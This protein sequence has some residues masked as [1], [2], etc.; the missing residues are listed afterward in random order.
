MELD[1]LSLGTC[2]IFQVFQTLPCVSLCFNTRNYS[3]VQICLLFENFCFQYT[4]LVCFYGS[5]FSILFWFVFMGFFSL[6]YKKNTCSPYMVIEFFIVIMQSNFLDQQLSILSSILIIRRNLNFIILIWN[7]KFN[8]FFLLSW[9]KHE[10]FLISGS[11]SQLLELDGFFSV[12]LSLV[13][14]LMD[15]LIHLYILHM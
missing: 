13:T 15:G 2:K 11:S 6:F 1:M 3:F 9:S 12:Q 5:V 14:F 8:S 4:L 10:V 7:S